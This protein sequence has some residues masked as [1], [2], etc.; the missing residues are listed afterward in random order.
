MKHDTP[1]TSTAP[2][3]S[4][5]HELVIT[6]V[7]DAPRHLVFKAWTEPE[8]L[9]RWWGPR[10]FEMTTCKID[11]RPGGSYRFHMRSPEGTEHRSH[12]IF[13]EVAEPERLVM[14][15]G[16]V[17]ADGKPISP[18]TMLTVTFEEH[19]GKTMLTLHNSGFGSATARD[20]HR[21]GWSSSLDCLAEYLAAA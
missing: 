3:E 2:T 17:D 12:G 4:T 15:G 18:E 19:E 1:A 14:A 10:G 5:E 11:L 6:R 16:W 21:G 8:R 7:F 13:R 20:S 9:M